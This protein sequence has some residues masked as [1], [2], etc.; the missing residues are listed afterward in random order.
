MGAERIHLNTLLDLVIEDYKLHKR[1]SL[2][3]TI[4]RI[5][6]HLRPVLGDLR[7]A[8]FGTATTDRYIRR[9]K[10]DG[11]ENSTINRE[12]AILRRAFSLAFRN[13]PPLV[14]REPYIPR[15]LENNVREGFL[16]PSQFAA[17]RDALPSHLKAFFV[18]ASH[19]GMRSGELRKLLWSQV[20]LVRGEIRLSGLQTKNK[21]PRTLKMY[22][23]MKPW[24][25]MA[26][27]DH[28]E[29]WPECQFV[30][31]YLGR[32]IGAHIKGWKKACEAVGLKGLLFHDL[33]RSA[34]RVMERAGVP[35]HVA[36]S[37]SGHR[38]EAVYRRYDIVSERDIVNA[39]EKLE[40]YIQNAQTVTESVTSNERIQ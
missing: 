31:H 29:Y 15:L 8:N 35:R 19:T 16:E 2:P 14:V 25:E 17:L 11:A 22:G 24:L 10:D 6:K 13:E 9:R 21:R 37:I 26:K 39:G 38:T 32:P 5:D 3:M 30:F 34:V 33:R 27:R 36:M 40:Q 28:D 18:V 20:D 23:D 1:A 12:L 7:A 4:S